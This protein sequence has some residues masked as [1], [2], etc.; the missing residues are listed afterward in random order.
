MR[1]VKLYK[2]AIYPGSFGSRDLC[3]VPLFLSLKGKIG[4]LQFH[5]VP[6]LEKFLIYVFYRLF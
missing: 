5:H 1:K 3:S 2:N 6:F 4:S